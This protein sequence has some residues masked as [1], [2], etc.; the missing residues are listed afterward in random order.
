MD[1]GGTLGERLGDIA[2][3]KKAATSPLA[4]VTCPSSRFYVQVD[5]IRKHWAVGSRTG[6]VADDTP[7]IQTLAASSEVMFQKGVVKIDRPPQPFET[8][9]TL[10]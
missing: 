7:G 6:A 1:S 8:A 9:N 3:I 10:E 2:L 5:W 4:A